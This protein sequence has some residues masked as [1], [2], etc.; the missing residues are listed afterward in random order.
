MT[1]FEGTVTT[2]EANSDMLATVRRTVEVNRVADL[3]TL[4]HTAVGP[5]SDHAKFDRRYHDDDD[6][7]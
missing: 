4:E 5:V 6:E 1:H 3:V 2:Y 7:A